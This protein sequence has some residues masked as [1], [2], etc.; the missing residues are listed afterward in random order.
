MNAMEKPESLKQK[1]MSD[2][3]ISPFINKVTDLDSQSFEL[4]MSRY[5]KT[6]KETD[7]VRCVIVVTEQHY[8]FMCNDGY[9]AEYTFTKDYDHF[10]LSFTESI[11]SM[12]RMMFE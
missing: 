9:E 4:Q 6:F 8:C 3:L 10:M 7:K 11:S 2:K 1:I 12:L 5:T